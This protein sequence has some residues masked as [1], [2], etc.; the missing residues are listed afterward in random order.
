MGIPASLWLDKDEGLLLNVK[1]DEY[2]SLSAI[3]N[4]FLAIVK[5]DVS[6]FRTELQSNLAANYKNP[7]SILEKVRYHFALQIN[8]IPN[9]SEPTANEK[10]LAFGHIRKLLLEQIQIKQE[11]NNNLLFFIREYMYAK[12]A[13]DIYYTFLCMLIKF[14]SGPGVFLDALYSCPYA[15]VKI[16]RMSVS[17][18]ALAKIGD[19]SEMSW[20][21]D[22]SKFAKREETLLEAHQ[23]ILSLI[24]IK[25]A[26][27]PS[28]QNPMLPPSERS[29]PYPHLRPM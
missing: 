12:L 14:T 13:P 27:R 9:V 8:K 24:K 4:D 19:E 2:L 20:L 6:R 23:W 29:E 22:R 25:K 21:P 17:N 11:D 15:S 26:F 5:P 16:S 18:T 1:F 10:I 28:Q 7:K 3:S